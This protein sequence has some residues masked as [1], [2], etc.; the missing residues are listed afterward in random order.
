MVHRP[1]FGSGGGTH[2]RVSVGEP[3]GLAAEASKVTVG[4]WWPVYRRGP[5]TL[6]V[7]A[8]VVGVWQP[9]SVPGGGGFCPQRR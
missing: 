7:W 1:W 8:G 9:R 3:L 6:T 5:V 4:R 2:G